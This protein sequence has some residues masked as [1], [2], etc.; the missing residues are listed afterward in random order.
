MRF[1]RR[2]QVGITLFTVLVI[3]S[4]CSPFGKGTQ[5]STKNYV[6]S[7][8]YSE[9]IKP[10]PIAKLQNTG[11]L[12]GPVRLPLYLDRTDIVTRASAN[13]VEIAEFAQWAGPLLENFPRVLAENLAVLLSTD[14]V[15]IFPGARPGRFDY[16]VNVYVTRFDGMVGKKAHLRARW[17]ILDK[18]RKNVL[19]EKH[20]ALEQP[21]ENNSM[22][23]LIQA[24]SIT[25]ADF[26]R[27]IAEAIKSL[28]EKK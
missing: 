23:A 25:V 28:V 18:K 21:T 17:S 13:K 2:S 8:L 12:V 7:S 26:S 16:N 11:I 4:G 15:A 5:Q 24:K 27:E 6:L 1:V 9:E 19:F 14:R 10:Q 3:I 22:E 20:S